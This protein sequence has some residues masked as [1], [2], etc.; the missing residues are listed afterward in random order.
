MGAGTLCHVS[1][2]GFRAR[3][4]LSS[5]SIC[6]LQ[7]SPD[8]TTSR[9]TRRLDVPYF[10]HAPAFDTRFY[11]PTARAKVESKIERQYQHQLDTECQSAARRFADGG[12]RDRTPLACRQ[13]DQLRARQM[14]AEG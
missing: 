5:S 3:D 11:S 4:W 12:V 6:S 10:V 13:L 2:G 9:R 14:A 7:A 8:R 1:L